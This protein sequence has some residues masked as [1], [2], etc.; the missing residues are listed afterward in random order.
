MVAVRDGTEA[1]GGSLRN[2][3]SFCVHTGRDLR[4][5]GA[6]DRPVKDQVEAFDRPEWTLLLWHY[7]ILKGA[8]GT[9]YRDYFFLKAGRNLLCPRSKTPVSGAYFGVDFVVNKTS[10][11]WSYFMWGSM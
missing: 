7:T 9:P 2:P 1:L 10:P 8:G 6:G 4:Q 5:W 11:T 3:R